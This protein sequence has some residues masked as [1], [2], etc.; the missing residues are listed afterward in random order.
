[1]AKTATLTTL[2]SGNERL[3]CQVFSNLDFKYFYG[4]KT[5]CQAG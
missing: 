3:P 4:A 1:M 5:S 2:S